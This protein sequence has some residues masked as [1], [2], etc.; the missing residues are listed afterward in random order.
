MRPGPNALR[1]ALIAFA[2]AGGALE[3][4]GQL[5]AHFDRIHDI[6]NADEVAHYL[7][8]MGWGRF[9]IQH[10]LCA[11]FSMPAVVMTRAGWVQLHIRQGRDW[12]G[13][14][15]YPSCGQCRPVTCDACD[16]LASRDEVGRIKA[17]QSAAHVVIL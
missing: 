14:C 5:C 3:T 2:K 1:T 15:E 13:G 6:P 11:H 16:F 4:V 8:G 17:H 9:D 12:L 7:L 10:P